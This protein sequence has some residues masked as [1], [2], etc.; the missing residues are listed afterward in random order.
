MHNHYLQIK[1]KDSLKI[2]FWPS[3]EMKAT[4]RNEK[5]I[6]ERQNEEDGN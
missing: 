1:K 4:I 2:S 3:V 5:T 6:E